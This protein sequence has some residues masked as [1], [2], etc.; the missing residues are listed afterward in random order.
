MK[1]QIRRVYWLWMRYQKQKYQAAAN[2]LK[3]FFQSRQIFITVKVCRVNE[4]SSK[5][6]LGSFLPDPL[7]FLR[8]LRSFPIPYTRTLQL[9]NLSELKKL[10]DPMSNIELLWVFHEVSPNAKVTAQKYQISNRKL[11]K[12]E[13]G[14]KGIL[15]QHLDFC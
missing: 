7:K 14:G 3:N 10:T 5:L 4:V 9:E 1:F 13:K 2:F 8:F 12:Y 11:C 6:I 15:S